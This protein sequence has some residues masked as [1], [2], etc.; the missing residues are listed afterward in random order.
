MWN[1]YERGELPQPELANLDVYLEVG[2]QVNHEEIEV[3]TIQDYHAWW[4][5]RLAQ[6]H[7]FRPILPDHR[8]WRGTAEI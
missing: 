1:E 4:R 5:E 2:S 7:Q 8:L 3:Q 6:R